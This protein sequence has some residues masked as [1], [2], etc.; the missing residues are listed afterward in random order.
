MTDAGS[1]VKGPDQLLDL[2]SESSVHPLELDAANKE[3]SDA[4][5]NEVAAR[6]AAMF[7]PPPSGGLI[8]RLQFIATDQNKPALGFIYIA[9]L[10]SPYPQAREASLRGLEKLGHPELV[11]FA[12]LSLH[13]N[14]DGVVAVASQILVEKAKG[15]PMIWK[16]LQNAYLSRKGRDEFHLS[17]SLLEAHGIA[18]A[19][20]PKK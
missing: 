6:V 9:N 10:R 4:A 2:L 13:D 15:D 17:N 20:L 8:Q 19:A 12:L 3:F 5:K 1:A 11:R 18:G 7:D 16:F 14:A